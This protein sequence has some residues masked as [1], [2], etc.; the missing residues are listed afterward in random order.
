MTLVGQF[1]ARIGRHTALYG[2]GNAVSVLLALATVA[3]FT[4]YLAPAE[5]GDYALFLLLAGVLTVLYN[6]GSLQGTY[7]WVYGTAD[8]D[9]GDADEEDSAG[10]TRRAMG[11]GLVLTALLSLIG[12]GVIAAFAPDVADVLTGDRG[13]STAVAVAAGAGA[14]GS[15]WRLLSHI[16]VSYTHLTLPTTPYV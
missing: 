6:L 2:A 15:V 8:E 16:P 4:R 13:D 3:V 14:L 11:T 7:R 5:F 9:A 12:T 1:G 10:D